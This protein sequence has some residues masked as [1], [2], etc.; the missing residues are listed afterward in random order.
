MQF[1]NHR[2]QSNGLCDRRKRPCKKTTVQ[3][4]AL[5]NST[6]MTCHIRETEVRTYSLDRTIQPL[7]NWGL[8]VNCSAI[9]KAIG[10]GDSSLLDSNLYLWHR[11]RF[12]QPK[13]Y[14]YFL[15]HF[16]SCAYKQPL[17]SLSPGSPL[18]GPGKALQCWAASYECMYIC[19]CCYIKPVLR[20]FYSI[21]TPLARHGYQWIHFKMLF[22]RWKKQREIFK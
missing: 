14:K 18:T 22:T 8:P 1:F 6:K 17:V 7:N 13:S 12:E 4:R 20:A 15:A 3:G 19:T 11:P 21:R 9:E 2:I 5:L 16:F 10:F